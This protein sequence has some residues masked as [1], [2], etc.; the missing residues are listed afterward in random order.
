MNL[1][2]CA[3]AQ[4]LKLKRRSTKTQISSI[5]GNTAAKGIVEIVMRS[6]HDETTE[7]LTAFI[8]P[9][10][11]R[12]VPSSRVDRNQCEHLRMLPLADASFHV[13]AGIDVLLGAEFYA[14]IVRHGLRRKES[15]P[16]AQKTS[17]GWI[18]FGANTGTQLKA[19]SSRLVAID[20]HE[21]TELLTRFWETE[22]VPQKRLRSPEEEE[23]ERIFMET[24]MRDKDGRYIV[25]IP[26][27]KP[28]SVVTDTRRLALARLTQ[29]ERRFAREPDTKTKYI[30]FS[31]LH[32]TP[33]SRH[34]EVSNRI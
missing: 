31:D 16:T 1:I 33:C 8:V 17:F 3:I 29:L 9:K 22:N 15:R 19:I 2:S 10:L 20:N 21:L 7:W 23:C 14:R 13:P 25:R 18:V 4:K 27:I 24:T 30:A 6:N 12:A 32:T 26:I 11:L 28:V 5:N 34:E